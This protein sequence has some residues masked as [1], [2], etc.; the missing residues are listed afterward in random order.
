MEISAESTFTI[1]EN[2]AWRNVNEEI[3]ILKLKSGEYYT[4]NEVGRHIWQAISDQQNVE[5]ITN[6]IVDQFEVTFEKA[7]EDV[8]TFL[9]KMLKESVVSL[10]EN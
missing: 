5:G 7:M 6:H 4:L 2:V 9:D 10:N 8:M 1:P 3:V